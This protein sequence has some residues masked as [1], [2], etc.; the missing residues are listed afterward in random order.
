MYFHEVQMYNLLLETH[1]FFRWIV[2][3]ALLVT[4]LRSFFRYKMQLNFSALDNF[5]RHTT[6]TIAHIQLLIGIVLYTQSPIVSYFWRNL[7]DARQIPDMLF[8]GL[9][10]IALML[11]A[12]VVV[13]IGSA[14]AKRKQFDQE[15]F[16]TIFLMYLVGL[17]IILVAVPWPFS[18]LSS[19]PY[20]R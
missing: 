14:V 13:S 8:F 12:V 6:A 9:I 11:T 15:K 19:R 10:H 18:P 7:K 4:I 3:L 20:I 2:L 16:R 17:V 1:S 5:L